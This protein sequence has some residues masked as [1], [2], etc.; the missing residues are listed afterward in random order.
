M[1]PHRRVLQRG[2]RPASAK[3]RRTGLNDETLSELYINLLR[4]SDIRP[5]TREPSTRHRR[6][7]FAGPRTTIGGTRHSTCC[8]GAGNRQGPRRLRR[9]SRCGNR[10][11]RTGQPDLPQS[12]RPNLGVARQIREGD[13]PTP[14]GRRTATE[15]PGN[16]PVSDLVL[17]RDEESIGRTGQLLKLIDLNRHDLALYQQLADRMKDNEAEAERAAT[18]IIES[19]PNEAENHAAMAELRQKQNRWDEAISHWE[20]VAQS[21]T[22]RTD[23]PAQTHRGPAS[24]KT[25]GRRSQFDRQTAKDRMALALRRRDQQNAPVA[26][27][28]AEVSVG[29]R[30]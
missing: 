7:L 8:I 23:R 14:I 28:V 11:D 5:H 4:T 2:H 15:R 10:E 26:G 20:Q 13:R 29:W 19:S 30:L 22:S 6:P 18:S 21:T 12:R 27:A 17:R 3:Q 9:S 25:M 16:P 1:G 24:P